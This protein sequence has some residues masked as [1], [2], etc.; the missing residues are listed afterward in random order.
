MGTNAGV[1]SLG[2][3]PHFRALLVVYKAVRTARCADENDN[4]LSTKLHG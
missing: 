1:H 4:A 3:Q 2:L